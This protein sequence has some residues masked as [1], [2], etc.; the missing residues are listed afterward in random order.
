[1][2]QIACKTTTEEELTVSSSPSQSLEEPE[3][4]LK[5][6]KPK[7]IIIPTGSLG[8][9]HLFLYHPCFPEVPVSIHVVDTR[10]Q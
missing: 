2:Q 7:T 10:V 9:S 8:E 1:M 6:E 4:V 5:E 3:E